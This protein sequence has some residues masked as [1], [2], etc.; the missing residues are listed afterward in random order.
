[1]SSR[2]GNCDQVWTCSTGHD[3]ASSGWTLEWV[4]VIKSHDCLH[5]V[6]IQPG[7]L[8]GAVGGGG[9]GGGVNRDRVFTSVRPCGAGSGLDGAGY[10]AVRRVWKLRRHGRYFAAR[11]VR[12]RPSLRESD[13]RTHQ[14]GVRNICTATAQGRLEDEQAYS[15]WRR[16]LIGNTSDYVSKRTNRRYRPVACHSTGCLGQKKKVWAYSLTATRGWLRTT[17]TTSWGRLIY[18]RESGLDI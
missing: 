12:A 11:R 2:F 18:N 14:A 13:L 3:D 7:G 4:A 10:H 8:F 6:K 15:A 17:I 1:M 9:K 16:R 5:S